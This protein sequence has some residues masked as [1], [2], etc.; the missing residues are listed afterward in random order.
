MYDNLIPVRS[1]YA[2][3]R[4][5]VLDKL[6]GAIDG[7]VVDHDE[8]VVFVLLHEDRPDVPF[9]T[10]SGFIVESRNHEAEGFLLIFINVVLLLVVFSF[11]VCKS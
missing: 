5:I 11:L 9:S 2:L 10:F 1:D 6:T 8:M 3:S 7:S 4:K